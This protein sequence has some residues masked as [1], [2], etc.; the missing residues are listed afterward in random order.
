METTENEIQMVFSGV[1]SNVL[2]SDRRDQDTPRARIRAYA[3]RGATSI[4]IRA[5][6]REGKEGIIRGDTHIRRYVSA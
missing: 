4:K 6:L 1:S 5:R 3:L 2:H